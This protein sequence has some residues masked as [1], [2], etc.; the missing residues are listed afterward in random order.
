MATSPARR[1]ANRKN[2]MKSTGPRTADGKR[3]SSANATKHGLRSEALNL[4]DEDQAKVNKQFDA[5]A[6]CLDL[7]DE[8]DRLM[9]LK[10]SVSA[11]KLERCIA[12]EF[13]TVSMNVRNAISDYD[14][15][16][17][18][19]V[20][21]IAN[22]FGDDPAGARRRLMRTNE[23]IDFL[24]DRWKDM[25]EALDQTGEF[26][27]DDLLR[28]DY[29]QGRR[30]DAPGI[31]KMKALGEATRGDFSHSDF[32]PAGDLRKMNA[33]KE[34]STVAL[35]K[36]L[37][38]QVEKL[39][40]HRKTLDHES[41]ARDRAEAPMRAMVDLSPRAVLYRR[42]ETA[43][44][45]E[46]A[47]AF[48]YFEGRPEW[49]G[50]LAATP[51]PVNDTGELA[52]FGNPAEAGPSASGHGVPLHCPMVEPAANGHGVPLHLPMA[53]PVANGHGV[54]FY[55]AMAG[56]LVPQ[57]SGTPCALADDPS[58]A[59]ENLAAT[60]NPVESTGALASFGDP[61]EVGH[62]AG[63]GVADRRRVGEDLGGSPC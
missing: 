3:R 5:L 35:D 45:R 51:D 58:L 24:I 41:A 33:L 8:A 19:E 27:H 38:E 6:A 59:P 62:Q 26:S 54:P 49:D 44:S 43:A 48:A 23:G 31:S 14:E 56:P 13:A 39:K 37:G 25:R 15:E 57:W 9:C 18:A 46:L 20:R 1:A 7:R 2:A 21:R 40:K 55:S 52:S 11:I 29:L 53:G 42:Y 22:G 32:D 4:T 36:L 34:S 28:V 10:A 63:P 30:H 16:R 47:R 12:H 50:N 60:P 17:H 61:A